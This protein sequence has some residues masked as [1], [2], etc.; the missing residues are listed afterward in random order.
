M[1]RRLIPFVVMVGALMVCAPA[2]GS[3]GLQSVEVQTTKTLS[4]NEGV[5]CS[6]SK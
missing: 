1:V 6:S 2:F 4:Q 5:V 3:F